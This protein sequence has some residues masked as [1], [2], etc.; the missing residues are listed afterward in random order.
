MIEWIECV[1]SDIG[2]IVGGATPST[3]DDSNYD[4]DIAWLTPKDLSTFTERYIKKGERSITE[5]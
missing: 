3:K 5:K 1:L 2:E 4:G